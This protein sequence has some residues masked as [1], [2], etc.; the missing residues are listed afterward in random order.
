MRKVIF[1][2]LSLLIIL[3]LGFI[4][5]QG[6]VIG[7]LFI[8]FTGLYRGSSSG[9]TIGF[10]LGFC[11]DFFAG[12]AIGIDSFSY[13]TIG[14]CAGLM[15]A[16]FDENNPLLQTAVSIVCFILAEILGG[17]LELLFV[18][19]GTFFSF[20]YSILIVLFAAPIFFVFKK[21]WIFWFK[22]LVAIR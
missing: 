3:I 16:R 7:L 14:F 1:Y 2:C 4:N 15:P 8:V 17:A 5:S 11:N 6:M 22:E 18:S 21:W 19:A 20:D 12:S 9:A 10:I 13:A